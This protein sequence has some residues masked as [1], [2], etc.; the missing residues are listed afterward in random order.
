[1][2]HNGFFCG[3][4]GH[5]QYISGSVHHFDNCNND[6]FSRLWIENF[7]RKLGHDI[8]TRT[9]VYYSLPGKEINDG[10]ICIRND[11]DI[12]SMTAALQGM[13]PGYKVL[14]IFVDH[15]NFTNKLRNDKIL[16]Q[17]PVVAARIDARMSTN[18]E[19]AVQAIA[20]QEETEEEAKEHGE[21]GQQ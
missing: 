5:L 4:R 10:L 7:L 1:V 18:G 14:N 12:L 3:L 15:T 20:E 13:D 19:V 17:E 6:T 21:E 9:H 16:Q 11:I 8:T 2:D